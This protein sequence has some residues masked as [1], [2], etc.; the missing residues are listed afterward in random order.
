M[1]ADGEL[2]MLLAWVW[3][4]LLQRQTKICAPVLVSFSG[5]LTSSGTTTTT[6]ARP[7]LNQAPFS[8]TLGAALTLV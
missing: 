4:S 7:V 1:E 6:K 8:A 2:H 5:W 3:I